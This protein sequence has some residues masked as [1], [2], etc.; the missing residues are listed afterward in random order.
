MV[1]PPLDAL[2][3]AAA[4]VQFVD[5]SSRI[6]SKG[7]EYH[8]S[9]DGALVENK[10]LEVV[11]ASIQ[12]LSVRLHQSLSSKAKHALKKNLENSPTRRIKITHS[13]MRSKPCKP[14]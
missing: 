2:T 9:A 14:W 8:K 5:F 1:V 11:A 6:I 4:V 13:P 7:N 10:E 12:E 3:I